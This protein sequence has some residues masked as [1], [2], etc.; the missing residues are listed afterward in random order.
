MGAR[1]EATWKAGEVLNVFKRCNQTRDEAYGIRL[2][3]MDEELNLWRKA[4]FSIIDECEMIRSPHRSRQ[5]DNG[6]KDFLAAVATVTLMQIEH[7][8]GYKVST[9]THPDLRP[10]ALDIEEWFQKR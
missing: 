4:A 2:L 8:M 3:R 6:V 1:G 10:P 7:L 5:S 9:I